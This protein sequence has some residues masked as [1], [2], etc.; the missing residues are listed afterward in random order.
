MAKA[1][2]L[3]PCYVRV[4]TLDQAKEMKSQVGALKQFCH[5]RGLENVVWY[6]DIISG[7]STR[8]PAFDRLQHD[9]FQGRVQTIVVWKLDRINRWGIREGM[10]L[11]AD[12]LG[13]QVR[14]I[15]TRQDLDFSGPIGKMIAGLLF[16]LARMERENLRENTKRGLAH[17]RANGVTLGKPQVVFGKQIVP[18]P[19]GSLTSVTSLAHSWTGRADPHAPSWCAVARD[20]A[21][22]AV[23]VI[24]QVRP[25]RSGQSADKERQWQ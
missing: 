17:A 2:Q 16:A 15:A 9:V 10:N 11:L 20:Q 6:K 21:R 12:W 18:L 25:E 3:T 24:L 1:R 14:V 13:K 7:A 5:D 4:S 19:A 22:P 8:R 23:A